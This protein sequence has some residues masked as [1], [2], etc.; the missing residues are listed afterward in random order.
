MAHVMAICGDL[1]GP[2]SENVEKPLVFACFFEGQ[3]GDEESTEE[4]QL[5]SPDRPGGGRGRV[6][7]PPRRLVSRFWEVG[8]VWCWF[9]ASLKAFCKIWS[10]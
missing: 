1:V 3:S 9:K 7:P 6:N 5:S 4:L 2:K 10:L 8:R